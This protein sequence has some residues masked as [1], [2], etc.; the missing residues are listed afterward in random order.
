MKE[1]GSEEPSFVG[2]VDWPV[3]AL[4]EL[5]TPGVRIRKDYR[6]GRTLSI[7]PPKPISPWAL[8]DEFASSA[9]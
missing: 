2:G 9:S 3:L 6:N 1:D 4:R 5:D 8:A 7:W